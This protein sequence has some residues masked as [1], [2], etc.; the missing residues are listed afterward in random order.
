MIRFLALA[1]VRAM[2][3]ELI[4]EYGG[5]SGVRDDGLLESALARP[6]HLAAYGDPGF[7]ALA[8][9]YAYGLSRNHP[10]IDGNKRVAFV[11]MA[12]FLELNG[13]TLTASQ[14]AATDAMLRLAS[15]ALSEAL[16]VQWVTAHAQPSAEDLSG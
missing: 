14:E 5:S 1:L 11:S 3:L 13:W 6:H 9:S 8:A 12:V 16:L 4:T 2:H 7:V 10:F 15:G